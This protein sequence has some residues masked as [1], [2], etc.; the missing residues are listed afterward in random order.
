[1][2]CSSHAHKADDQP[3]HEINPITVNG[4][5][6]SEQEIAEEVQH[7]PADNVDQ[8]I[9]TAST[10]LLIRK[11]L[12]QKA[13]ESEFFK[14]GDGKEKEEQAIANLL[15]K[16]V[17]TP[18]VSDEECQRYFDANHERFFSSPLVEVSHVLL[19]AAPEDVQGRMEL[20]ETAKSLI[21]QLQGGSPK[22][23]AAL[24]K[25]YS[26]CPS[27]ETGGSLGQISKGQTVPEF[28]K[29][30]FAL[31]KGVSQ[32]PIETRYGLHVVC[33]NNRID[34]EALPYEAV[35]DRIAQYLMEASQRKAIS[36]YIDVVLSE[37]DIEGIEL[38]CV[39]S[40]L[41]Q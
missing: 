36:Q 10:A 23:F 31:D 40:P 18:E 35:K 9:Q 13:T 20:K 3:V 28:E 4:E 29:V 17:P 26:A 32:H 7:H 34:G 33:V 14:E 39:D 25:E 24:A 22:N 8:A 12:L 16:E 19:A 38:D 6:I 27:K 30:V 37:A 11:L 1:M 15:Q 41:M 21:D 5:L 2:S